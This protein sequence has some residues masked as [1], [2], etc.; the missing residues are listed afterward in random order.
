MD[1]FRQVN[2][3]EGDYMAKASRPS[4][5]IELESYSGNKDK[6]NKRIEMEDA[7]KGGDDKV[8]KPPKHLNKATKKVYKAIVEELKESGI[9][10]N[11]DSYIIE[12]TADA[13]VRMRNCTVMIDRYGELVD[14]TDKRT[15]Q[16]ELM[17]N[18][19]ITAYKDYQ[20]IFLQGCRELGM[21]PSQR[22]KIG[23]LNIE[24]I[25]E[26]GLNEILMKMRGGN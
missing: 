14:R 13:I 26:D 6:L 4:K 9:L 17:K 11:V 16:V 3:K 22:S 8:Y 24:K 18:P 19:A 5:L 7:L 12:T 25:E 2:K 20:Q 23:Q 10:T 15:K 1:D 21:S